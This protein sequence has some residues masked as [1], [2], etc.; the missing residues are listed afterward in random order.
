M[1]AEITKTV[2]EW[3]PKDLAELREPNHLDQELYK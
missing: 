1:P 2:D 3:M